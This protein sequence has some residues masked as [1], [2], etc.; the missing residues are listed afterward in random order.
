MV[1]HEVAC[2]ARAVFHGQRGQLR[3]RYREGQED[4]LGALG[5]VVNAIV[6]WNTRY[7]NAALDQLRRDGHDVRDDDLRRLSPLGHDHLNLLG[8]YQ[9]APPTSPTDSSAPY[10]I[11]PPDNQPR[12]L[13]ARSCAVATH[14]PIISGGGFSAITCWGLIMLVFFRLRELRAGDPVVITRSDGK[15][16]TFQVN[17][18]EQYPKGA[19]PSNAVYG[20]APGSSLRLTTGR[21]LR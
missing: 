18:V 20:P 5:L 10:A 7:Q 8:R 4:Q 19:F 21:V 13:S 3:Q 11:P 17:A 9:S 2:V 16:V 6:L 12:V 14:T 15:D 1:R